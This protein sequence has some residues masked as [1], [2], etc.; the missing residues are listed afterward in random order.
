MPGGHHEEIVSH[1][2]VEETYEKIIHL[3][4]DNYSLDYGKQAQHLQDLTSYLKNEKVFGGA[5]ASN[6]LNI[7]CEASSRRGDTN[8]DSQWMFFPIFTG[9][10][11]PGEKIDTFKGNCFE[12]IQMQMD[13][14]NDEKTEVQV[15]VEAKKK[16]NLFCSDVF[17]YGNTEVLWLED[18]F[19]SGKHT[20]KLKLPTD[21][22]KIDMNA[23]G[24][25]AY[26][27]CE[28]LKDELLSVIT[29]LK[30]FIGGLGDHGKTPFNQPEVP[31]YMEKANVEFMKW[32]LNYTMEERK[33]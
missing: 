5:L 9:T 28:P 7:T 3:A 13:F 20:F 27:F 25:H 24:L 18:L 2:A 21:A 31:E 10:M 15:V 6:D 14:A 23:N 17:F 29:T 1:D 26:M 16:K 32:G 19:F 12:E 30:A 22:A 33:I 11:K 4:E 8:P